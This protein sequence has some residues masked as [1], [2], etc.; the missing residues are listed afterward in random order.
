MIPDKLGREHLSL[1]WLQT[2]RYGFW[3][4]PAALQELQVVKNDSA[5][6]GDKQENP[7]GLDAED[8]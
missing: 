8:E 7:R 2:L 4:L 5:K 3:E 6:E 1:S